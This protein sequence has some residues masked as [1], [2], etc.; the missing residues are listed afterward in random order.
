MTCLGPETA[1]V[2]AIYNLFAV[3]P[4]GIKKLSYFPCNLCNNK[5]YSLV[6]P[7]TLE[8]QAAI[9]LNCSA[10]S[11][12]ESSNFFFKLKLT[13]NLYQKRP[14]QLKHCLYFSQFQR[15]RQFSYVVLVGQFSFGCSS[16]HRHYCFMQ[17]SSEFK[18]V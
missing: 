11:Q 18:F 15:I 5:S 7:P 17:G 13:L 9:H 8:Q 12:S 10:V 14:K 4:S 6:L 16:N 3:S 1:L 2:Q